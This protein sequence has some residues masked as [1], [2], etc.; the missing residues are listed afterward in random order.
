MK[1]RHRRAAAAAVVVVIV[2]NGDDDAALCCAAF[3]CTENYTKKLCSSVKGHTH[4][5]N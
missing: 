3:Q 1:D 4:Q 2:V 5:Q